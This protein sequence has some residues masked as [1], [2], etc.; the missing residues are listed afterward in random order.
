MGRVAPSAAP[1]VADVASAGGGGKVALP[2]FQHELP[3][4]S[5]PPYMGRG[6]ADPA[7]FHHLVA[8]GVPNSAPGAGEVTAFGAPLGSLEAAGA[9]DDGAEGPVGAVPPVPPGRWSQSARADD[10]M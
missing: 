9:F 2:S 1:R 7:C 6:A 8:A 4:E 10:P 3:P 5:S